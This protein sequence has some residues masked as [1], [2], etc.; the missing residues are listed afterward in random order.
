MCW[1]FVDGFI[2]GIEYLLEWYF[3]HQSATTLI[4]IPFARGTSDG[5]AT[6][7]PGCKPDVIWIFDTSLTPVVTPCSH[8]PIAMNQLENAGALGCRLQ[9]LLWDTDRIIDDFGDDH[10]IDVGTR[11]Q[12]VLWIVD[13]AGHDA[14]LARLQRDDLGSSCHTAGPLAAG[15]RLPCDIDR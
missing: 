4:S 15:A 7:S 1:R 3:W 10:D 2:A 9:R 13:D 14:D 8:Q 11:Q 12:F 5:R 6:R